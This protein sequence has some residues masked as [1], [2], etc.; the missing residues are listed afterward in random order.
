M[1]QLTI[2]IDRRPGFRLIGLE[3]ELDHQTQP[4]L[5]RVFDQ[6]LDEPAPRI[7]I[8]A[9]A[10][11]F[12]NCHGLGVLAWGQRRAEERGGAIRLIG[13]KGVLA[14]LLTITQLVDLFPPYTSL[15]QAAAW[16]AP[17]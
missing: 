9:H 13:V 4:D 10:L 12:C 5:V 1:T 6:L 17:G 3:G 14:R 16:S 7:V 8:D 11:A 2:S 15:A